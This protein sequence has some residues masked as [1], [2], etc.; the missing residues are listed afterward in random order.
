MA[1]SHAAAAHDPPEQIPLP[2][3]A[4]SDADRALVSKLLRSG[5]FAEELDKIDCEDNGLGS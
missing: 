4:I 2:V 3:P 1:I 5:A